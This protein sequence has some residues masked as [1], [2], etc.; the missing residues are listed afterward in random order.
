VAMSFT[1]RAA[2]AAEQTRELPIEPWAIGLLSFVV[3][4]L[5]L[6]AVLSFGKGR[7]HT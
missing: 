2:E 4:V 3:L 1:V 7:E 5:L 6:L